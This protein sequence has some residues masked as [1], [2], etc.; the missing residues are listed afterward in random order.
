[1]ENLFDKNIKAK[2]QE[3][4]IT[5][6]SDMWDRIEQQLDTKKEKKAI[7]LFAWVKPLMKY[8][9]AASV[10][11]LL[12]AF[13]MYLF[14]MNIN[15]NGIEVV[16]TVKEEDP[17][18]KN[19]LSPV[20]VADVEQENAVE[21]EEITTVEKVF[22]TEKQ[23]FQNTLA[24]K[25]VPASSNKNLVEPTMLTNSATNEQYIVYRDKNGITLLPKQNNDVQSESG[26][27][28]IETYKLSIIEDEMPAEFEEDLEE[29]NNE[30]EI[31]LPN[32]T[33]SNEQVIE[34]SKKFKLNK[35]KLKKLQ[36]ELNK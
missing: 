7:V 17:N 23:S 31:V 20:L 14:N 26:F 3:V 6:S 5:P 18:A 27:E 22:V 2:L 25:V 28:A 15:T 30:F 19:D 13:S 34:P 1:M 36:S 24:D 21:P 29:V 33:T 35:K 16:E 4:E 9:I 11:F 12:G 10:A 8:G 32:Q